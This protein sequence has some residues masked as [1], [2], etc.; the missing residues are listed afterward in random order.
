[1]LGK[2]SNSEQEKGEI[3]LS[4]VQTRV[5]AITQGFLVPTCSQLS[6]IQECEIDWAPEM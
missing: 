5:D 2:V 3:F 6:V 4:G 1:M